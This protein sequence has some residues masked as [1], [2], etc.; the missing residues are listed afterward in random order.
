MKLP[1]LL[2][3]L[4]SR[5]TDTAVPR[6]RN[7][8]GNPRAS[9]PNLRRSSKK[10]DILPSSIIFTVGYIY[11]YITYNI[12]IYNIMY[13]YIYKCLLESA[14]YFANLPI[15]HICY[16]NWSGHSPGRMQCHS[17]RSSDRYIQSI[18]ISWDTSVQ[19]KLEIRQSQPGLV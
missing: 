7:S 11:I 17:A 13:I 16:C 10:A 2:P 4:V 9:E 18:M 12:Y 1:C 6:S 5:D 15:L 8:S 14:W 3:A 19:H